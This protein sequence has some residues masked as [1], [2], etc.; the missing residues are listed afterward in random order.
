MATGFNDMLEEEIDEKLVEFKGPINTVDEATSNQLGKI[1][2]DLEDENVDPD[3]QTYKNLLNLAGGV[4]P[5]AIF[6]VSSFF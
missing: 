4:I 6:L 3:M 2:V 5:V 1:L